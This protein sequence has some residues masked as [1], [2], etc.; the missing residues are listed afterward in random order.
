MSN[1]PVPTALK[2]VRGNPGRRPINGAEPRPARSPRLPQAPEYLG[3][4]A[5]KEWE[6][7]VPDLDE[8]GLLS[9]VDLNVLAECCAVWGRVVAAETQLAA[10]GMTVQR[11]A[12]NGRF[13]TAQNPA[14]RDVNLM[15]PQL[16]KLLCELGMTPASR[17]RIHVEQAKP[18]DK[19]TAFKA[20][21]G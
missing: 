21:H 17:S 13:Y 18:P 9:R 1:P 20:K 3:E 7:V 8:C 16:I 6:R 11:K 10:E 14:F 15:L 5:R 19:L 12:R 2:T 4:V